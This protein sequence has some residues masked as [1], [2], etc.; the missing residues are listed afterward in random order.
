MVFVPVILL[1]AAASAAPAPTPSATLPPVYLKTIVNIKAKSL[2]TDLHKVIMPFVVIERENNVRFKSMDVQLGIY[3]K[4]YRPTSDAATDPNG[5][6][7]INGAQA[8]AA[9]RIDQTAAMMYKDITQAE[10]L[11]SQSERAVPHGKD[12]KLDDLR[13][14]ARSILEMQRQIADRYEEQA[15]TYLN[16]LGA[17]PPVP[18]A[19]SVGGD[20]ALQGTL[21]LPALDA[22]PLAAARDPSQGIQVGLQTPAPGS[23]YGEEQ[24]AATSK[25]IVHSM[26]VQELQFVHPALKA[27]KECDG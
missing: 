22:D 11:I 15:G 6:P 24:H 2:C 9:A 19:R 20:P 4:W 17:L 5:S 13:D 1:A 23:Q 14:R 25:E 27:V 8:L 21:D 10:D 12:P 18:D 7:E 26:V 16:S 3:H